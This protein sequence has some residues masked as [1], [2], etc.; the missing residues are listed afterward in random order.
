MG[1]GKSTRV[2]KRRS[3]IVGRNGGFG[4]SNEDRKILC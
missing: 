4:G 2:L 3:W 1:D